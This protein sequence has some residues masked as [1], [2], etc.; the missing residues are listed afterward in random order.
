MQSQI[1]MR[2]EWYEESN[3]EG[4]EPELAIIQDYFVARV[5]SR[6]VGFRTA[7]TL[8]RNVGELHIASDLGSK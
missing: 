7:P 2:S 5:D 4:T 3:V 6:C 1:K 8:K